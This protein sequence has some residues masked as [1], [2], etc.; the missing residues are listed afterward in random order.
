MQVSDLNMPPQLLV[1]VR[2]ESEALAA[3]EGGADWIDLKEP[4][5]GPLGNVA[6]AVAENVVSAVSSRCPV[7]AALG[8]LTEWQQSSARQILQ[9]PGISVVKV[10]LA[11]CRH[12]TDWSSSW[13][14][15]NRQVAAEQKQLAA[16]AYADSHLASSPP[17]RRVIEEAI[18]LKI[19]FLLVDTFDKQCGTLMDHVS[20]DELGDLLRLAR[21]NGICTVVAGSLTREVLHRLPDRDIDLLAVRGAACAGSRTDGVCRRQTALFQQAISDRW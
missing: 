17:V 16:V 18:R 1:S 7:S 3:M 5:R 2:D 21:S 14:L 15:L 10:G 9:L 19:S 13:E 4:S 11:G 6:G 20:P 12:L 8:E